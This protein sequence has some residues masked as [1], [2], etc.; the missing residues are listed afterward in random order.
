VGLTGKILGPLGMIYLIVTGV[1]PWKAAY[2]CLTN[3]VIWLIPFIM[4]LVDA[5]SSKMSSSTEERC[6]P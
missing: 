1:W 6:D 2:L 3:D 5:R 4:Y